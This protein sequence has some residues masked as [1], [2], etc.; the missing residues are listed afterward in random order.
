MRLTKR[1]GS[2]YTK[3]EVFLFTFLPASCLPNLLDMTIYTVLAT[4]VQE[5]ENHLYMRYNTPSVF[6]YKKYSN[7]SRQKHKAWCSVLTTCNILG[8]ENPINRKVVLLID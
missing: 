1:I 5:P 7:L 3:F 2:M 4:I 6:F 8:I